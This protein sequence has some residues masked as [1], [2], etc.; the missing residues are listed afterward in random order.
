MSAFS[1]YFEQIIINAIRGTDY[2]APTSLSF[3]LYTSNPLD[4]DSGIEV[5][6][7]IGVGYVPQA[8]TLTA[9]ATVVS[10]GSTTDNVGTIVF[11]PATGA[12][13]SIT[14]WAIKD[15]LTNLIVY[16][17]FL[18]AKNVGVG[19]GYSVTASTLQLLVR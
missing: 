9:P 1:S 12:W 13:G 17:S 2:T 6:G 5:V 8:I 3:H 15:Q 4:D 7:G 14:H 19:D 10:T 16:G 11:G 18:A